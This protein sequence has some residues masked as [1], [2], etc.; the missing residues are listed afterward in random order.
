MELAPSVMAILRRLHAQHPEHGPLLSQLRNEMLAQ[1]VELQR[2]L[3]QQEE[4]VAFLQL[5]LL[6][7]RTEAAAPVPVP[8]EAVTDEEVQRLAYQDP[9]TGLPNEALGLRYLRQQLAWAQS[10]QGSVALAVLDIQGLRDL[11]VHLGRELANQVLRLLPERITPCLSSGEV[12]VRGQDDEFWLIVPLDKKGPMGLNKLVSHL[13]ACLVKVL[14]AMEQPIVVEDQCV[15]AMLSCGVACSQGEDAVA[16]LVERAQLAVSAGKTS[17]RISFWQPELDKSLRQRRQLVPLLRQALAEDQF[18]LRYQPIMKLANLQIQ[19]VECLLRWDHPQ[20]GLTGPD[21]FLQA[22]CQSGLIVPI[23]N[24]VIGQACTLSKKFPEYYVCLNVSA[25]ELLQGDF[26]KRLSKVIANH[27]VRPDRMVV[28]VSEVH[29]ALDNPRFLSVLQEIRRWNVQI[30]VDDF[31][32]DSFSLRRLEK[33][34]AKFLKLG[35][36]VARHI[37]HPM[38][39]GLLKGAVLAADGLGCRVIAEGIENEDQLKKLTEHGCH[40]GQGMWLSPLMPVWDLEK[41]LGPN[42]LDSSEE[43]PV[44]EA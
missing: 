2:K 37:D 43:A 13:R 10:G 29:V 32:F 20:D 30:A 25:Q 42:P 36:E 11:N 26:A 44:T 39:Q 1:L 28:E 14:E 34:Q 23:G 8:K 31:S 27:K 6:E 16:T 3:R 7:N 33:I 24:W 12:L 41:A 9:V 22:A 35:P 21:I 38:Y 5:E 18:V 15:L 19:G 17:G 4:Q 40:W